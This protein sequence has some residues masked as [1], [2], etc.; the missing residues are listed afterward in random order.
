[1]VDRLWGLPLRRGSAGAASMLALCETAW[2]LS[3]IAG[4]V[5]KLLNVA[6][7]CGAGGRV[8]EEAD[9]CVYCASVARMDWRSGG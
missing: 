8:A 4:T 3:S 6:V 2:E 5:A 9:C 1:V 7:G